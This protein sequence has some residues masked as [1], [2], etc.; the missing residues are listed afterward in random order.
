MLFYRSSG[1]CIY[2]TFLVPTLLGLSIKFLGCL[3]ITVYIRVL[4]CLLVIFKSNFTCNTIRAYKMN[5]TTGKTVFVCIIHISTFI[6]ILV[7]TI[8]RILHTLLLWLLLGNFRIYYYILVDIM[9]IQ[10][11]WFFINI[12]MNFTIFLLIYIIIFH[13]YIIIFII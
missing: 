9:H 3:W 6:I 12:F 2:K 13:F 7:L 10:T 5:V 8:L 1:I 4:R 11:F